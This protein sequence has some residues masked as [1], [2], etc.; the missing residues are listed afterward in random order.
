MAEG[1]ELYRS[2]TVDQLKTFLRER[3]IP[4]TGNKAE[5]VQKV[6]DV[7]YTDRLEEEIEVTAFQCVTYTSPP[8]FEQLPADGWTGDDFPLVR[9][10]NVTAYL[11][12]K[13]G[14]TKNFQT[15]VRLCQWLHQEFS[16]WCSFMSV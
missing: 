12:E 2:W 5:L 6:A 1:V 3:R 13:G 16:N 11:K 15:G 9:E 10:G 8:S 7:V 14:Y 4:L